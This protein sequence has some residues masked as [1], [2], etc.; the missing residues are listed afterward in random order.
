V[1]VDPAWTEDVV[2]A[3]CTESGQLHVLGSKREWLFIVNAI[4]PKTVTDCPREASRVAKLD[5]LALTR[6][7][8]GDPRFFVAF[9]GLIQSGSPSI[10]AVSFGY[11]PR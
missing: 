5:K 2:S 11:R 1:T 6:V 7:T 10:I 9:E 8:G 3:D 4:D